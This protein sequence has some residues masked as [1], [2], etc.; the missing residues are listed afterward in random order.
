MKRF[1]LRTYVHIGILHSSLNPQ[2]TVSVLL[3]L[4]P[5]IVSFLLSGILYLIDL[6]MVTSCRCQAH[7]LKHPK[8][9]NT[10]GLF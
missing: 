9:W 4:E 8:E 6:N 1:K 10:L 7:V 2:L 3:G 5:P